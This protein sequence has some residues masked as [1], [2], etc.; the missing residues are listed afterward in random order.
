L[1][2]NPVSGTAS[3]V[4][5][6]FAAI[7][8]HRGAENEF[9]AAVGRLSDLENKLPKGRRRSDVN[10]GVLA[11]VS[12]D[13]PR[14]VEVQK[15]VVTTCKTTDEAATQLLNTRP[16]TL[17]GVVAVLRYACDYGRRGLE[18][19]GGYDDGDLSQCPGG[20]GVVGLFPP[21]PRAGDRDHHGPRGPCSG[22]C[23]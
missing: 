6:I 9:S 7:E 15:T 12:G 14:W 23:A 8:V 11:I 2:R 20:G 13:D 17:A 1:K 19:P 10:M 22:R 21:Q 4:D 3:S 5:P 18:F 16:R